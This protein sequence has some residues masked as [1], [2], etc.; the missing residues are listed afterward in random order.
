MFSALVENNMALYHVSQTPFKEITAINENVFYFIYNS[1]ND[2][3]E[4]SKNEI[5]MFLDKFLSVT[6]DIRNQ[7]Y[8]CIGIIVGGYIL[9]YF[10][11]VYFFE[12][13]EERKESYLAIFYQIGNTFIVTSRPTV[14]NALIAASRPAPGPLT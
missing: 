11:F 9:V 8:M 2:I 12:R 5:D 4:I 13:V 7:Y 6:S 1:L 10:V 3:M 14:C